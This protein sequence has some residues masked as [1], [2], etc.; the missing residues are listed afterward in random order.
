MF[1]DSI[2]SPWILLFHIWL[3]MNL[4]GQSVPN[5]MHYSSLVQNGKEWD[6]FFRYSRLVK[7]YYGFI[8]IH[9]LLCIQHADVAQQAPSPENGPLLHLALP[10]LEALHKAWSS[11]VKKEKYS[12]FKSALDLAIEKIAEYYDKTSNSDAFILSM[13]KLATF[14]S[15][16]LSYCK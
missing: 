2:S 1:A 6:C 9:W 5:L 4:I 12:H 8:N 3:E 10:A 11:R 14:V 7:H 15:V 16:R 13:C